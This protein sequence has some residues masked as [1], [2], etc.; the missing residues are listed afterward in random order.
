[1]DLYERFLS[2][3]NFELAY[4]RLKYAPNNA[5]K[6]FYEKDLDVFGFLLGNNIEQLI[7]EIK[8]NKYKPQNVCRYYVP[9]KNYLTR[10]ISLLNFVDLLVYQA[11]ANVLMDE[12]YE[13]LIFCGQ[14][15]S[16]LL[17]PIQA[18]GR[19]SSGK[20]PTF[21]PGRNPPPVNTYSL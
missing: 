21:I 12:V 2:K 17:Q 16:Q 1:M 14:T 19:F 8:S 11:I 7:N 20:A 4:S 9:K 6:F 5:Y 18:L 10:P 3:E 15:P 13:I